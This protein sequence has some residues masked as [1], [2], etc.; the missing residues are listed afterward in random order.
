M[1]GREATAIRKAQGW[2]RELPISSGEVERQLQR[3]LALRAAEVASLELVQ[4]G[5][6]VFSRLG[7]G[8][9][10]FAPS[11][12]SGDPILAIAIH[13]A[14]RERRIEHP[15]LTALARSYA[16]AA[17]FDRSA[18]EAPLT[19]VA[20]LL[21]RCGFDVLDPLPPARE[22][23]FSADELLCADRDRIF[24]A[25]R[26][27]M[28][29]TACG[30]RPFDPGDLRLVL[31]ALCI[32][33][34]LDWDIQAVAALLRAWAYLGEPDNRACEWAL[35][36]LLDQQ[37]S[38]GRF[39]LISPESKKAR[40]DPTDQQLYFY[41]TVATLWCLAEICRPGFLLIGIEE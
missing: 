5:E 6:S 14:L 28:T 21:R 3:L 25:C 4:N 29:I 2:V 12:Y 13:H 41:P 27:V 38:D 35:E 24:D 23:C 17:A 26:L 31:P 11:E 36:W 39:G 8:L 9:P 10:R 37:Q 40:N 34:A 15:S 16:E 20:D 7:S 19:L 1:L 33:Y 30:T 18:P 32:S 22:T